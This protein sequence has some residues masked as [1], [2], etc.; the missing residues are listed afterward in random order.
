[1]NKIRIRKNGNGKIDIYG[2][3]NMYGSNNSLVKLER[4]ELWKIGNGKMRKL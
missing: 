2:S 4:K 3:F 1:M